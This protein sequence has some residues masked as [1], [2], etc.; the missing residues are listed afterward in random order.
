MKVLFQWIVWEASS[1]PGSTN[2][3]IWALL[4]PDPDT[5]PEP[6]PDPPYLMC[7]TC[8]AGSFVCRSQNWPCSSRTRSGR[9]SERRKSHIRITMGGS[10]GS[11][12]LLEAIVAR[13][14]DITSYD[15]HLTFKIEANGGW[16]LQNVQI[17]AWH[18][19]KFILFNIWW[20]MCCNSF[21]P[22][23]SLSL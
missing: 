2:Q 7:P 5:N 12:Q 10:G 19:V 1:P 23:P 13:V 20:W 9:K 17:D 16:T 18:V 15:E 3:L 14:T 22:F 21:F 8:W 6:N 11:E 4:E